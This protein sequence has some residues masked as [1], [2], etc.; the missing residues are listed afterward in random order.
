[1]KDR[2]STFLQACLLLFSHDHRI[3]IAAASSLRGRAKDQDSSTTFNYTSTNVTSAIDADTL[4]ERKLII[5]G[6]VAAPNDYP[7]FAHLSGIACGGTLIA[8][9]IVLTAGHVSLFTLEI[10]NTITII[11]VDKRKF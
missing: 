6:N 11:A 2:R 3:G 4:K 5:G 7:Y 8:P 9:D 1:M 10:N